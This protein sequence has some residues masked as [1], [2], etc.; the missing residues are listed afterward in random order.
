[1]QCL[2]QGSGE[3]HVD[4]PIRTQ[5]HRCIDRML[6]FVAR[7]PAATKATGL[8]KNIGAA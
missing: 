6:D 1:V 4:E 7:H 8:V 3:I 2:E 5:A